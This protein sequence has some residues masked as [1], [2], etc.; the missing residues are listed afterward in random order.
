[1]MVYGL[2]TMNTFIRC[3][4]SSYVNV[5]TENDKRKKPNIKKA[6]SIR[7]LQL[8]D[9]YKPETEQCIPY[10][11]IDNID[12]N[13]DMSGYNDAYKMFIRNNPDY[14]QT[15]S[16]DML[17]TNEFSRLKNHVYLDYTG[18]ALYP[19]S[20]VE[21]HMK[22]LTTHVYGNTHSVN[23]TSLLS[24]ACETSARNAVLN[25]LNASSNNYEII[26][27]QNASHALKLVGE[28]YP[29]NKGSQYLLTYD[30][31]NSLNGIRHFAGKK[32]A[33][34]RYVTLSK[35]DLR[36]DDVGLTN[37]LNRINKKEHNLFALTAQSNFSGVKHPLKYIEKAQALGW[38]VCL[39]AAA[40]CPT[41]KLD[42]SKYSPDFVAISI[43]KIT[44][45]P[46]GVGCLIARKDK[47]QKMRRPWYAGGTVNWALIDYGLFEYAAGPRSFEDGT[48]DF[49]SLVAIPIALTW[50]ENIDMNIVHIRIMLLT[51][52][53]INEL[54]L[55]KHY[56]GVSVVKIYGPENIDMRGGTIAMSMFNRDG[57]HIPLEETERKALCHNIS[58][59]TGCMC[60]PGASIIAL[61]DIPLQHK[62]S[63]KEDLVSHL[64]IDGVTRISIGIVTNFADVYTFLQFVKQIADYK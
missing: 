43:Y 36:I 4:F 21:H 19:E 44:G 60:N 33:K 61:S 59:R 58:L 8:N 46:T 52:Y 23:P 57:S 13:M 26:F 51:Q 15:A 18:A 24:N 31:H 20:I 3:F 37:T 27:T 42:L 9:K 11:S 22:K 32:G 5:K 2:Y 49:L 55:I 12:I 10:N 30:A 62:F 35:P 53:L 50:F 14:L 38:D 56:N 6:P 45:Y 25:Y 39:D 63:N 16:L 47:L 28:S 29:F 17:R 34:V 48:I 7:C 1:M 41:N 54:R 64:R 40:Y